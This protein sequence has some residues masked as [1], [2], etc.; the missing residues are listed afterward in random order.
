MSSRTGCRGRVGVAGEGRWDVPCLE[1]GFGG[2]HS[3]IRGVRSEDSRFN[4]GR[5]CSPSRALALPHI[6]FPLFPHWRPWQAHLHGV[7]EVRLPPA[8]WNPAGAPQTQLPLPQHVPG[9]PPPLAPPAEA[10]RATEEYQEVD[11]GWHGTRS[12]RSPPNSTCCS[13]RREGCKVGS[14]TRSRTSPLTSPSS[15]PLLRAHIDFHR[16]RNPE[17][18]Q[19]FRQ[20][21]DGKLRKWAAIHPPS[22]NSTPDQSTRR[23]EELSIILLDLRTLPRS[24]LRHFALTSRRF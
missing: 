9:R 16:L 5:A 13:P 6:Q 2:G 3:W 22:L 15:P 24:C 7:E 18:Q 17:V 8:T 21:I 23:D 4:A 1:S 19:R 14:K 20:H 12:A 11:S 10:L